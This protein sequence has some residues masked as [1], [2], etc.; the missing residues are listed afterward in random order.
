MKGVHIQDPWVA[1]VG[2]K[3]PAQAFFEAYAKNVDAGE[4]FD[5]PLTRWYAPKAVYHAQNAVEYHGAEAIGEWMRGPVFGN[6]ERVRHDL[7]AYW[8]I[9][10]DQGDSIVFMRATRH[11]YMKG[12]KTEQPDVTVP[13]LWVCTIGA[14]D[15]DDGYQGLQFKDIH[16]GW[17]TAKVAALMRERG[18][19]YQGA[20]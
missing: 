9:I 7:G 11:V 16:L 2:E 12:N 1:G 17:D 13:M 3:T 14:A 20:S 5:I 6:F 15:S 19:S 10:P 18:R 8:E 4:F